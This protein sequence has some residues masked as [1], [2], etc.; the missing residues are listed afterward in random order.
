MRPPEPAVGL[1]DLRGGHT[2][3]KEDA[4]DFPDSKAVQGGREVR[5]ILFDQLDPCPEPRE[6][7]SGE[8]QG[9]C[10]T[11]DSDEPGAVSARFQDG[12]GMTTLTNRRVQVVA[13]DGTQEFQGA[14]NHDG[15][16][17]GV[18]GHDVE[19]FRCCGCHL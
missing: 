6:P 5:E 11:V 2:E 12:L 15:L 3:V 10:V 1:V 16:M 14:L 4:V 13:R 8:F 9:L 7:A 19:Y 18:A 17:E